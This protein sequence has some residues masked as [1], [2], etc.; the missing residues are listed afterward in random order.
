MSYQSAPAPSTGTLNWSTTLLRLVRLMATEAGVPPAFSETKVGARLRVTLS[1]TAL[2]LHAG[3]G[4]VDAP[5]EGATDRFAGQGVLTAGAR[6]GT[7]VV[8][9]RGHEAAAADNFA[10][11]GA[12]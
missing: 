3:D 10:I 1:C 5:F 2:S 8:A 4:D 6:P 9:Q 7:A 12:G 11:S